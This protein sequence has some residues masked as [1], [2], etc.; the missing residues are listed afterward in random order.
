[1]L[2]PNKSHASKPVKKGLS[3]AIMKEIE[4]GRIYI[5]QVAAYEAA[6][7]NKDLSISTDVFPLGISNTLS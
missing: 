1:M 2:W 4:S 3:W 5:D 6:S 7:A